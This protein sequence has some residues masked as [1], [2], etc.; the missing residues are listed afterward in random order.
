[1]GCRQAGGWEGWAGLETGVLI[2]CPHLAS[3]AQAATSNFRLDSLGST[4]VTIIC[5]T[6]CKHGWERLE[7]AL[8]RMWLGCSATP[9]CG[10][11]ALLCGR[12]SSH[13][14]TARSCSR[15]HQSVE[16]LP[17]PAALRLS[18]LPATAPGGQEGRRW[19]PSPDKCVCGPHRGHGSYL[20][21][22]HIAQFHHATVAKGLWLRALHSTQRGGRP[23]G[24]GRGARQAGGC[25]AIGSLYL[26]L[27]YN[28][29]VSLPDAAHGACIAPHPEHPLGNGCQRLRPC[30]VGSVCVAACPDSVAGSSEQP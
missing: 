5:C 14:A 7:E 28:T 29:V 12:S 10:N 19:A 18:S 16:Y 22:L 2:Q 3:T 27:A 13:V 25:I 20:E 4:D 17:A 30:I 15:S 24:G 26:T 1:M 8:L 11:T 9:T 23:G 21:T 6:V